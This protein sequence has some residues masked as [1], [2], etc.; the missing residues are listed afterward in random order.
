MPQLIPKITIANIKIKEKTKQQDS[1][2]APDM[3]KILDKLPEGMQEK[4]PTLIRTGT[5]FAFKALT[6]LPSP[7]LIAPTAAL[8]LSLSEA[9]I[10]S[11]KNLYDHN[12]LKHIC[13]EEELSHYKNAMNFGWVK[14]G[15][16]WYI[17]HPKREM[18]NVLIEAQ[19]FYEYIENE[20]RGEIIN[21]IF[22]HCPVKSIKIDKE[23]ASAFKAS[24][25]GFVQG[26]NISAGVGYSLVKGNYY[27]WSSPNGVSNTV[28]SKNE[29]LWL[30]K[31]FMDS[32]ARLS[33]GGNFSDTYHYDFT[34]GLAAKEAKTIGLDIKKHKNY[35][36]RIEIQC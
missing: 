17:L 16:Q 8:G 36:Y 13:T 26:A 31:S 11:L 12:K 22:S 32:V 6:R 20:Q 10:K 33:D 2:Q 29:Y 1:K 15:S 14:N 24:G 27:N 3:T 9:A 34:F 35:N 4:L 18:E 25:K 30:E 19:N 5:L 21:Y 28:E 7:T 23:E